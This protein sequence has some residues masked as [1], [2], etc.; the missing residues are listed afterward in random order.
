MSENGEGDAF[1]FDELEQFPRAL[2]CGSGIKI[3]ANFRGTRGGIKISFHR[4][5]VNSEQNGTGLRQPHQYSLMAW[6]M[7]ASFDQFD[8]GNQLSISLDKLVAQVGM[9]PMGTSE[10]KPFV[11][12]STCKL[13]MGAL[14]D[15][16]GPAK[17]I[18]TT[19]M[20]EIKVRT[21]KIL[22]ITRSQPQGRKLVNSSGYLQNALSRHGDD[23]R[24][25][26]DD[27]SQH[28]MGHD[29]FRDALVFTAPLRC[30]TEDCPTDG[31]RC[32]FDGLLCEGFL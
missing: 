31:L 3:H 15:Q 26:S 28:V 29:L 10:C 19:R 9:I 4:S 16:L 25:A 13:I 30:G 11:V 24:Q 18:V 23:R 7:A 20:V 12:S 5:S 17:R 2:H 21:D 27:D 22:N 32:G 14:Y 1:S 6:H 8:P